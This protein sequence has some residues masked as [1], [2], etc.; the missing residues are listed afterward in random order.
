M[1][2]SLTVSTAHIPAV[3]YQYFIT[4]ETESCLAMAK[5]CKMNEFDYSLF[6]S[7]IEIL[8]V[9]PVWL[10]DFQHIDLIKAVTEK[11]VRMQWH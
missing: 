8:L 9:E 5:D 3:I 6:R 4:T 11:N 2:N 10:S 1:E 7:T